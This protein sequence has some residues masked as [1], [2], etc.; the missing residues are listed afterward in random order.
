MLACGSSDETE[1]GAGQFSL[2]LTDGPVDTALQVVVRFDGVTIKPA[3]DEDLEFEFDAPTDIDLLKLTGNASESLLN[4]VSLPAGTYDWIRLN[5]TAELDGVLDSFIEFEDGSTEELR[6]PSGSQTGLKL[7]HRFTVSA[8]S[9]TD[10]TIDFD[11]RKSV[12]NPPGQDGVILKPTLRLVNNLEVGSISGVVDSN[13]ISEYCT[14]SNLNDGA[15]YVYQGSDVVPTDLQGSDQDAIS[16]AS[17][18]F[19]NGNYEFIAGFLEDGEYTVAYTCDNADDDPEA[20]EEL[21]FVGAGN[22]VVVAN[23]NVV[24]DFMSN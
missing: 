9:N 7:N 12:T 5:V 3:N 22:V 15:V 16:S 23:E 2:S 14:D 1:D 6:V 20:N 10:F 21:V 13:I 11:L 18:E 24:Y 19:S 4:S 17:V 8:G